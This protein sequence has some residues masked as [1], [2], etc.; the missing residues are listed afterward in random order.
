MVLLFLQATDSLKFNEFFL[1]FCKQW[2]LCQL[3][4]LFF[5]SFSPHPTLVPGCKTACGRD[6]T[7]A[8]GMPASLL[9][10]PN[11]G[12]G[13]QLIFQSICCG[14]QIRS[15]YATYSFLGLGS[16][17]QSFLHFCEPVPHLSRSGLSLVLVLV[18]TRNLCNFLPCCNFFKTSP[19]ISG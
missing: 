10:H 3:I 6:S 19:T 9:S 4:F 5:F 18:H 15:L 2:F 1:A 12:L 7:V 14:N 13:C 8:P 11:P 17:S 16:G